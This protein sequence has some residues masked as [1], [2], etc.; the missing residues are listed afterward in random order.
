MVEPQQESYTL[1]IEDLLD[2][3]LDGMFSGMASTLVNIKYGPESIEQAR[4]EARHQMVRFVQDPAMTETV[5]D[6][7]RGRIKNP[8]QEKRTLL[9]IKDFD[10]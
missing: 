10:E 5:R 7:I 1:P 4:A 8:G 3:F 9:K 2:I 6:T